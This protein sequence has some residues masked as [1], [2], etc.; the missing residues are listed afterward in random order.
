MFRGAA[1]EAPGD[2]PA[3]DEPRRSSRIKAQIP[4]H[5]GPGAVLA[6][7]ARLC[8]VVLGIWTRHE[9]GTLHMLV[10]DH[11]DW[12]GL[13]FGFSYDLNISKLTPATN[14]NGGPEISLIYNGCLPNKKNQSVYCPAL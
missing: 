13:N 12:N 8:F 14:L 3:Q 5:R 6:T 10:G 2:A 4:T 7:V 9:D 11:A 1:T